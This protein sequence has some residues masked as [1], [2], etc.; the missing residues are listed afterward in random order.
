MVS[1]PGTLI[2]NDSALKGTAVYWRLNDARF[3]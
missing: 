2:E 3:E 1:F